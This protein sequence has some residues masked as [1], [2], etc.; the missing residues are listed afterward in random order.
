M[1]YTRGVFR[2]RDGGGGVTELMGGGRRRMFL[3]KRVPNVVKST[4]CVRND[5]QGTPQKKI[6]RLVALFFCAS[7]I[8]NNKKRKTNCYAV[9][10]VYMKRAVFIF[11]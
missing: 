8:V 11:S 9:R 6:L 1:G 2:N 7:L 10:T 5:R 3:K 4:K